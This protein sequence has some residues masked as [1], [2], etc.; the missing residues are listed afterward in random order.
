MV[1]VDFIARSQKQNVSITVNQ[2]LGEIH[3]QIGA[4]PTSAKNSLDSLFE[5]HKEFSDTINTDLFLSMAWCN[6]RLGNYEKSFEY[7]TKA[8]YYSDKTG[9][10]RSADIDSQIAMM[11][12]DLDSL[13]KAVEYT[14]LSL[15]KYSKDG[16][17]LGIFISYNSLAEIWFNLEQYDSSL[18]YLKLNVT[19]AEKVNDH[20]LYSDAYGNYAVGLFYIENDRSGAIQ[21]QQLG[22]ASEAITGDSIDM[23]YSYMNLGQY[24]FGF[25]R[26]SSEKYRQK[27]IELAENLGAKDCL[28]DIYSGTALYLEEN[29]EFELALKYTKK[30]QVVLAEMQTE[31][32]LDRV[33]E[34]EITQEAQ[35]KDIEIS[36]LQLKH[37]AEKERNFI[38]FVALTVFA[39]LFL[40][41]IVLMI[42][43]SKR[44]KEL[45]NKNKALEELNQF[46]DQFFSI[47]AH[48]L[49]NS[50]TSFQGIGEIIR[51]YI[52]SNNKEQALAI[53]EKLDDA[54]LEVNS[55]LDNLLNWSIAQIKGV[56]YHP[57]RLNLKAEM[58]KVI[59]L[60][61]H[62]MDGKSLLLNCAID[63][64]LIIFADENGFQLIWRNLLSNAIKFS[65]ENATIL[66][67]AEKN[68]EYIKITLQ[69][70]G[71]GM[72][73]ELIDKVLNSANNRSSV[74]TKGEQGTGLGLSLAMEFINENNADIQIHSAPGAGTRIELDWP[75]DNKVD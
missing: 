11:Y 61:R 55:F 66:I 29:G 18:Y 51:H 31:S 36:E 45:A 54:S 43:L 70:E 37:E 40:S 6:Q 7:T 5:F 62:Q 59:D 60:F 9:D 1:F 48:D 34:W 4:D 26:D 41:I 8:K 53:A 63:E 44:R 73:E 75:V 3:E 2:R 49:R 16:D 12:I 32:M 52:D 67:G 20:S 10:Y 30:A 72:S 25:N 57:G 13:Y 64:E 69:D 42:I 17:E 21:Y 15:D 22:L 24:Y 74:G 14:H 65:P 71:V 38:L 23:T 39:V 33:K 35:K 50:V 56:P 27:S 28:Y 68:G 46:K 19:L 47:I 58:Q